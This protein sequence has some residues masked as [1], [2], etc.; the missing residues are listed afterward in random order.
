M[1]LAVMASYNASTARALFEANKKGLIRVD[2]KIIIC[3]NK[4]AS[5]LEF[6]KDNGI[7][8]AVI[9]GANYDYECAKVLKKYNIDYV[10]LSGYMKKIKANM[11]NAFRDKIINTHP[12]LLPKFGGEGM[13]GLRVHKAVIKAKESISGVTLHLVNEQYDKGEILYQK[14]LRVNK[15]DDYK[16]LEKKI[17]E[18]EKNACV[19]LFEKLCN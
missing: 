6:A 10:F 12:S 5:A 1:N 18:L 7:D 16:S 15:D 13:Y 4:S 19:K 17:K 14:S 2:I 9:N 8:C 3:N 11:L